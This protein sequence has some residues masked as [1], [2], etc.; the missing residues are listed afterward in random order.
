MKRVLTGNRYIDAIILVMLFTSFVH[1]LILL[2]YSDITRSFTKLNYFSIINL[3]LILPANT[4]DT[5]TLVSMSVY[6][7]LYVLA[8]R[9]LRKNR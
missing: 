4:L 7:V 2:G 1:M 5:N 8:L 9:V 3:H 6:I